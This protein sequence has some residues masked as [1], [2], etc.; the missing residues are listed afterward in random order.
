[1]P[2]VFLGSFFAANAPFTARLIKK[3]PALGCRAPLFCFLRALALGSG[4]IL[5]TLASA[6]GRGQREIGGVA[7]DTTVE[8]KL[9]EQTREHIELHA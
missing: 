3:E 6:F 5:G 8:G 4:M 2:L 9:Q 7:S 1:L